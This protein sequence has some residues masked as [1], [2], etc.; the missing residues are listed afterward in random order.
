MIYKF[1]DFPEKYKIKNRGFSKDDF[2]SSAN[3]TKAEQRELRKNLKELRILYRIPFSDQSETFVVEA[4]LDRVFNEYT[5]IDTARAI[6]K[7]ISYHTIIVVTHQGHTKNILARIFVFDSRQNKIDYKRTRVLGEYCS[8]S[9]IV[10]SQSKDIL[11]MLAEIKKSIDYC[12]SSADFQNHCIVILEEYNADQVD[13]L[14]KTLE[15][16]VFSRERYRMDYS[17][18]YYSSKSMPT[19]YLHSV[20]S[21][22]EE[23][24]RYRFD[25]V[26]SCADYCFGLFQQYGIDRKDVE[27][28]YRWLILYINSCDYIAHSH[29][30]EEMCRFDY[31]EI[32]RAFDSRYDY[33]EDETNRVL[34]VDELAYRIMEEQ[35]TGRY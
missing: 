34:D 17:S 6:A 12:D 26:K 33:R 15:E 32:E 27:S 31:D 10:S 22:S 18:M 23:E 4:K 28:K 14:D 5:M 1:L 25:F 13:L 16:V 20:F 19:I 24:R 11:E 3:L 29:G 30:L 9:F 21:N 2:V 8:R 35:S 7:S